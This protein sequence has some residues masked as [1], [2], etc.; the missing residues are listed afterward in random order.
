MDKTELQALF[1]RKLQE[2]RE[3]DPAK[4]Q[5]L[6]EE[7]VEW[8]SLIPSLPTSSAW[9]LIY[10]RIQDLAERYGFTEERVVNDLFDPAAIDHFMFF[11]QL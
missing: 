4:A 8:A 6:V 7:L 9:D 2:F 1:D 11:L 3:R 10:E 5:F